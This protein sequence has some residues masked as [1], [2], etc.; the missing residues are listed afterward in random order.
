MFKERLPIKSKKEI[1]LSLKFQASY[2]EEQTIKEKVYM[3]LVTDR[4]I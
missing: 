4:D 1:N 3:M 2:F